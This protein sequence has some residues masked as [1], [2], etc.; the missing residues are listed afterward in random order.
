MHFWR[1]SYTLYSE[2]YDTTYDKGSMTRPYRIERE[3]PQEFKSDLR[4]QPFA[5]EAIH[6]APEGYLVKLYESTNLY[7]IHAKRIAIV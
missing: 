4:F 6:R 1:S 2:Y 3:M 5:I 7:A